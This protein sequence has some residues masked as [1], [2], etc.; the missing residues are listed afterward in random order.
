MPCWCKHHTT[1]TSSWCGF[2]ENMPFILWIRTYKIE[3]GVEGLSQSA[4]EHCRGNIFCKVQERRT[5]SR[6]LYPLWTVSYSTFSC[7]K[8]CCAF[9]VYLK[10]YRQRFYTLTTKEVISLLCF[11]IYIIFMSGQ[12][13]PCWLM[14]KSLSERPGTSRYLIMMSGHGHPADI[15]HYLKHICN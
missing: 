2:T 13:L 10:K 12:G 6:S 8:I 3:R 5:R 14:N 1:S 9:S 4:T 15:V 7:H 11:F